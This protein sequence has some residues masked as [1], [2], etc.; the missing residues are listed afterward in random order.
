MVSDKCNDDGRERSHWNL[1]SMEI[2]ER[3][4]LRVFDIIL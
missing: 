4:C 1:D 3:K 2:W